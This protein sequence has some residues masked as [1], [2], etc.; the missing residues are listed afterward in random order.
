MLNN[1]MT[2]REELRGMMQQAIKDGDTD[3]F[4]QSFDQ[5]IEQILNEVPAPAIGA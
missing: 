1:D 5:M 4:Y 3:A 2:R